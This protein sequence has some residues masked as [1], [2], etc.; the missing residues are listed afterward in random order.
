MNSYRAKIIKLSYI[1]ISTYES[2]TKTAVFKALTV[3]LKQNRLIAD[4]AHNMGAKRIMELMD[5][6]HIYVV[7]VYLG[8]LKDNLMM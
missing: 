8:N 2:F 1:I 5:G 7:L 3:F 6:Y 4:E